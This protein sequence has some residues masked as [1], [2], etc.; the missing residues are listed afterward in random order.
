[1]HSKCPMPILFYTAHESANGAQGYEAI[2]R[3]IGRIV[4]VSL[5]IDAECEH[6]ER[7]H[8]FNAA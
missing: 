2:E 5:V 6:V 8:A 4:K 1:M 3:H 7:M